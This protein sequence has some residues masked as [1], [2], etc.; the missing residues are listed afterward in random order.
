VNGA[1]LDR[2]MGLSDRVCRCPACEPDGPYAAGLRWRIDYERPA[3]SSYDFTDDGP[4]HHTA[5]GEHYLLEVVQADDA[6]GDV[7]GQT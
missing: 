3:R 2:E 5:D 4:I 6:R 1:T 7:P